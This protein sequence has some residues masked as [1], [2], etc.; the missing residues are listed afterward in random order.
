MQCQERNISYCTVIED[1]EN[2]HAKK[3]SGIESGLY[4]A[5]GRIFVANSGKTTKN[6]PR[7]ESGA[8]F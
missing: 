1:T 6:V 8:Q 2:N 3:L 4:W 5:G 7:E